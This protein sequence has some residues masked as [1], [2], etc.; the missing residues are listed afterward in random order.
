ML[1][2]NNSVPVENVVVAESGDDSDDE[3]NYIKVDKDKLN[4]K[5]ETPV[6]LGSDLEKEALKQAIDE[7]AV[8]T[9]PTPPT[10]SLGET[11]LINQES[12]AIAQ[13]LAEPEEACTEVYVFLFEFS[14]IHLVLH[15]RQLFT[16]TTT[17]KSIFII[18]LIFFSFSCSKKEK[19][20]SY[21]IWTVLNAPLQ[22]LLSTIPNWATIKIWK[23]WT[24]N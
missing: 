18:P 24:R 6:G 7:D 11:D 23:K 17:T 16:T 10:A 12:H 5:L 13:A 1:P 8:I 20:L 21:L 3:W 2:S 4:Q 9:S 14:S 19:T 15:F 22:S